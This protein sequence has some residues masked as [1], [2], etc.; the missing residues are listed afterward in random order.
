MENPPD[1]PLFQ[2]EW[3]KP[4]YDTRFQ[5]LLQS[6]TTEAERARLL[7]VS[8]PSSSDWL[9]AIPIPALGLHLDPMSLKIVCGLR[10]GSNLCHQYKCICGEMVEP[11]GRHGLACKKQLGRR[12]RHDECNKLIKRG[13]DQA[14]IPSTLE[15]QGLTRSNP[16]S[17]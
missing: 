17:E 9:Y 7:A 1:N 15:P 6:T 10:L 14:K 2:S 16:Y 11:N 3:D 8:A 5:S 4:L 13:L 12:S